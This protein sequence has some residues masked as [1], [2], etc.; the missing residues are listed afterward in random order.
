MGCGGLMNQPACA[1][2]REYGFLT[3]NS[4][5]YIT[6]KFPDLSTWNQEFVP[7]KKGNKETGIHSY[8][9]NEGMEAKTACTSAGTESEEMA[10]KLSACAKFH[11]VHS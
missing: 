2:Y 4:S 10:F 1:W 11:L 3:E 7:I 6:Q 5:V 9:T 8:K